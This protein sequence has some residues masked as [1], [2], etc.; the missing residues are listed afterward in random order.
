MVFL[1][2]YFYIQIAICSLDFDYRRKKTF[3][4]AYDCTVNRFN[5]VTNC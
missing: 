2:R 3:L 4:W 5:A 1:F